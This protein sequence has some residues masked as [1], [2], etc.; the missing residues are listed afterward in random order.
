MEDRVLA[1][2]IDAI[3]E[4][5]SGFG[6]SRIAAPTRE[7]HLYGGSAELD[8]LSLVLL[9][10]MIEASI[11]DKLD[12]DVLIASEK[13]MSQHHSPYRTVGTLV[14]FISSELAGA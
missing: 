2:V 1:I 9:I 10:G 12:T 13:A 3:E 11:H 4:L 14:D 8:S 5:N 6:H 7:T